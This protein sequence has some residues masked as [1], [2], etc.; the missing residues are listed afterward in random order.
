MSNIKLYGTLGC[1]LCEE[2]ESWLKHF[3]PWATYMYVDIAC[4]EKLVE[5]F[6]LRI[7]VLSNGIDD[8]N[9]PFDIQQVH[10]L[11]LEQAAIEPQKAT[12]LSS[13][14]PL[15]SRRVLLPRTEK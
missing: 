12:T 9:W 8:V 14:A 13:E 4:D 2:A 1:H 10:R 3:F 6:G 7:P 11:F 5:S 15:P